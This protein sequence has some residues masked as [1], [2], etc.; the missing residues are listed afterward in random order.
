MSGSGEAAEGADRAGAAA[1]ADVEVAVAAEEEAE[2]GGAAG[3]SKMG[4]RIWWSMLLGGS[5]TSSL[6]RCSW[7]PGVTHAPFSF[8][9]PARA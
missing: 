2:A 1:E 7:K 8:E 4:L 3:R 6:E 5:M 9:M